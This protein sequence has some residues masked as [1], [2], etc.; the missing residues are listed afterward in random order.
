MKKLIIIISLVFVSC[1]TKT[2]A[3]KQAEQ[4]QA[5]AKAEMNTLPELPE[6][7]IETGINTDSFCTN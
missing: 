2:E 5:E 3:Q 6:Q 1:Q 7:E 4:I